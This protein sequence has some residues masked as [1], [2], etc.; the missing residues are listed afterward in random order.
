MESLHTWE[1]VIDI[2]R[3]TPVSIDQT[4][5]DILVFQG[6]AGNYCAKRNCK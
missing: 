4:K 1:V 5:E 3:L 2:E 6:N